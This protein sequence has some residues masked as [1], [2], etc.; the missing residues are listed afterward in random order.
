[1]SDHF[2]GQSSTDGGTF[3]VSLTAGGNAQLHTDMD[4]QSAVIY[5]AEL[6]V[7]VGIGQVPTATTGFLLPAGAMLSIPWENLNQVYFLNGDGVAVAK[8]YCI[9]RKK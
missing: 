9:Y 1:M 3:Q 4:V 8:V 2:L 6:L 7:Y 5:T